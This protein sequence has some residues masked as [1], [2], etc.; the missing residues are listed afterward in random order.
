MLTKKEINMEGKLN[1]EIAEAVT[2]F[3]SIIK[4]ILPKHLF[5]KLIRG[6]GL[7]FDGY[8]IFNSDDDA[9]MI[10]WKAS[11]RTNNTLIKQYVEEVDLKIMIAIDLSDNMV[12]GSTKKLK[13]EYSAE[14]AAALSHIFLDYGS[15]VG[16]I[17]FND[18]IVKMMLPTQGIKS[19]NIFIFEL[20]NIKNYGGKSNL[21][22]TLKFLLQTLNESTSMLFII[23]DFIN[24][25]D[26]NKKDLLSLSGLIETISII[27]QDPLDKSLPNI[28]K[29]IVIEDP[30]T[31][32]KLLINP[33]I[34]RYIYEERAKKRMMHIKKIL[35]RSN[36]DY[37]ELSTEETFSL[38]LA[39]FLRE[40][41]RKRG[42]E[43]F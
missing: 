31:G 39:I 36:I 21:S 8:R 24:L 17:L 35:S 43:K 15:R 33:K 4:K 28:N 3:E 30:S 23:S 18:E 12:F 29:E 2:E 40:R 16:F 32:E 11:L 6:K 22:N 41:I 26:E 10:D 13:C 34:A 19:F 1:L 37:L 7:D 5:Y 14:M 27:V 9:T 20:E 38:D 25:T 42:L